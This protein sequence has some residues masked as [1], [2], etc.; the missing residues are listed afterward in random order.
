MS[1]KNKLKK[2]VIKEVSGV[3]RGANQGAKIEFW[4]KEPDLNLSK[5]VNNMDLEQLAEKLEKLEKSNEDLI[6]KNSELE[7][8]ASLSDDEKAFLSKMDHDKKKMFMDLDK[9]KKK[10]MMEEEKAKMKK[11]DDDLKK[12]EDALGQETSELLQKAEKALD[13]LSKRNESLETEVAKLKEDKQKDVFKAEVSKRVPGLASDEKADLLDSLFKM[14]EDGRESILK[15]LEDAEKIK[16]RSFMMEKGTAA[17]GADDPESKLDILVKRHM[18]DN[19]G[20]TYAK[21][22][23]AVVSTEEGASLY[24]DMLPNAN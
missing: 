10:K 22:L 17:K 24:E 11:A 19:D 5:G 15:S 4:K 23:E 16:K 18:D 12:R 8:L 2:L 7:K 3:D 13:T 14:D 20:V 9:E 1:K 6:A 21:A